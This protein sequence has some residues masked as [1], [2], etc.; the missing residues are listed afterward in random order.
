MHINNTNN[1]D[2]SFNNL[3]LDIDS[4]KNSTFDGNIKSKSKDQNNQK[5]SNSKA[6]HNG[7]FHNYSKYGELILIGYNGSLSSSA[8]NFD[9][10]PNNGSSFHHP[11]QNNGDRGRKRSRF[12]VAG[13]DGRPDGVVFGT[14]LR[15]SSRAR[16]LL[17]RTDAYSVSYTFVGQAPNGNEEGSDDKMLLVV[18]EYRPDPSLDMFQIGRSP[19]KPI[20]FV[21]LDTLYPHRFSPQTQHTDHPKNNSSHVN[22]PGPRRLRNG[23]QIILPSSAMAQPPAESVI[24]RFACRLTVGRHPPNP[25]RVYAAGF[26]SGR[27]IFLGPKAVK[28]RKGDDLV[29]GL[30]TNGIL[31][32]HD[33]STYQTSPNS[34]DGVNKGREWYEVS[35][36]GRLYSLR[37]PQ[38]MNTCGKLIDSQTNLLSDWSLIDICGATLLWRSIQGLSTSPNSKDIEGYVEKLNACKPQCPVRLS[39]LIVPKKNSQNYNKTP[40]NQQNKTSENCAN[41][42][43]RAYVYLKCGHVQGLHQWG[44]QGDHNRKCPICQKIGPITALYPGYES[45]FYRSSSPLTHS[46]DPCGHLTNESTAKYWSEINIPSADFKKVCPFCATELANPGYIKL[47]FQGEN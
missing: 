24:S 19:E 18:D 20:D 16:A 29:D 2:V 12:E 1:Y 38:A 7:N 34:I 10:Y 22:C 11:F 45:A 14:R 43:N 13:Q 46:F 37:S 44:K 31:I 15:D 9:L 25:I 42:D 39:T 3:N 28:W 6:N 41:S 35:V 21:V 26:D 47:H 5:I 4:P 27:N 17:A 32:S 36:E 23:D 40:S 8:T 30:T 33:T